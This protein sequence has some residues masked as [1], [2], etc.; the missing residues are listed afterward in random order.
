[1]NNK[2]SY[3]IT[4]NVAPY[5]SS[6]I[7]V[8]DSDG[9]RI[10]G[11]S[12]NTL[13]PDYGT[14]LYRFGLLSDVHNNNDSGG[15]YNESATENAEDLQ[16]ALEYFNN[17]QSV[18]YTCICGDVTYDGDETDLSIY[19]NLVDTYSPNT[20]VYTTTGNHDVQYG[21]SSIKSTWIEKTGCEQYF[22]IDK[23]SDDTHIDHFIFFGCNI[24]KGMDTSQGPYS[25]EGLTWLET[26]LK[27]YKNHRCFIFTHYFFPDSDD[28]CGNL[29]QIYPSGNWLCGTSKTKMLELR[30]TY[31]NTIWFSGHSHWKWYLQKYETNANIY[32][33]YDSDGNPASGWCVHVP[34]C[35]YPIDSDYG[36]GS[37]Q[38]TGSENTSMRM[39]KGLESEGAIVDVYDE[40]IDIRGMDLKNGKYLPI[41]QY[42]LDTTKILMTDYI[43]ATDFTINDSK[44]DTTNEVTQ[45]DDDYVLVKFTD[46]SQGYYIQGDTFSQAATYA[47]LYSIEY[48][49]YSDEACTTEVTMSTTDNN[50]YIGFTKYVDETSSEFDNM[51][52]EYT[53]DPG[54][55]LVKVRTDETEKRGV[56]FGISSRYNDYTTPTVSS[57]SPLYVKMKLQMW[58]KPEAEGDTS[59][60][61]SSTDTNY[62]WTTEVTV[63]EYTFSTNSVKTNK[64]SSNIKQLDSEYV[65]MKF[66]AVSEGF[67]ITNTSSWSSSSTSATLDSVDCTFYSDEDMT[68][69]VSV[70]PSTDKIGFYSSTGTYTT[71]QGSTLKVNDNST[72]GAQFNTSSS[73]KLSL[74]VYVKLKCTMTFS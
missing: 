68:T 69:E 41:A 20:Y 38:S 29:G 39:V 10:G 32:R 22:V 18:S 33:K 51:S 74:P 45:L 49:F 30:N 61:D 9:N 6:K 14:R 31:K 64:S 58:F 23:Q 8:Y 16:R 70:T 4:E 71:T 12:L 37:P 35:A 66:D 52:Y 73:C 63:G 24:Y 36:N 59:S 72:S 19:S 5:A 15:N 21:F 60:T 34:S 54:S 44:S 2:Y 43:K 57:S 46:V 7:G 47:T 67:L 55:L 42:R 50:L 53:F 27:K 1:M 48:K 56:E 62:D 13:K 40:Y 26:Q 17:K 65:L 11:I 3:F 25:N 28:G